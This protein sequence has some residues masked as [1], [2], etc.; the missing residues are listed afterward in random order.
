[1][2]DLS[3]GVMTEFPEEAPQEAPVEKTIGEMG[4]FEFG[5]KLMRIMEYILDTRELEEEDRKN[6]SVYAPM[7]GGGS[8]GDIGAVLLE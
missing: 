6:Q 1:M 5:V 2:D 7:R 4:E 8:G 3:F